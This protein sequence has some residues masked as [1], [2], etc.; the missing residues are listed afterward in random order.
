[1]YNGTDIDSPTLEPE[2]L[3]VRGESLPQMIKSSRYLNTLIRILE[4]R[5]A[6]KYEVYN[7]ER[8]CI[9]AVLLVQKNVATNRLVEGHLKEGGKFQKALVSGMLTGLRKEFNQVNKKIE[10][11]LEGDVKYGVFLKSVIPYYT[12]LLLGNSK[13]VIQN[14]TENSTDNTSYIS[15]IYSLFFGKQGNSAELK[16]FESLLIAWHGGFGTLTPSVMGP[17]VAAGTNASMDMVLASGFMCSGPYHIGASQYAFELLYNFRN[18]SKEELSESI[19]QFI[20]KGNKVPGFG[21]PLFKKDPRNKSLEEVW[22]SHFKNSVWLGKYQLVVDQVAKYK[23]LEP[24]IDFIT[25]SIL[26]EFGVRESEVAPIVALYARSAAVIAHAEEKKK[27][28]P[29]GSKSKNARKHLDEIS[30][31]WI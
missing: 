12:G 14:Y 4:G 3:K 29:F 25:A 11:D 24:N 18:L 6:Y 10:L 2:D 31:G 17:R 13:G 1:M 5:D 8:Y 22:G 27:M 28:P 7:I 19:L 9:E 15:L 23:G 20:E 26:L 16:L 21:H 30:M